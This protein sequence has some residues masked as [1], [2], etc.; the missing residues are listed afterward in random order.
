MVSELTVAE[1]VVLIA[2][3]ADTGGGATRLGLDWAAAGATIAELVLTRRIT[4]GGD[5]AVTVVDPTPTGAAHV[6]AVLTEAEGGMKVTRLLRRTRNGAPART[7]T[8]LVERGVLQRR[9]TRLLGVIPAH[10]YPAADAEAGA[11]IRARLAETVLHGQA[12]SERTA[13]L[14]GVL[15]AARL[16]RR[17]VPDGERRRVRKRMGEIAKDQSVSPAVRT[18]IARTKGAIAAM[19]AS[20]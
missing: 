3:D 13:A 20:S 17:A 18:A 7:I 10:R 2:L 16:W 11:E 14:I 8:N 12:P 15:D 4:V 9:R 19:A 6:D 1:E 5:D